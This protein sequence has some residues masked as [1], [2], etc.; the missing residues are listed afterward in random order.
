MCLVRKM[1]DMK[2]DWF[3]PMLKYSEQCMREAEINK[4]RKG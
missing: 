2:D 3:V 4:V 1:Q